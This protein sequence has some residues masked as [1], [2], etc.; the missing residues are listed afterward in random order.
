MR[1]R[2]GMLGFFK[3]IG[4][5]PRDVKLFLLYCLFANS[6]IA[7]FQ[8]IFNLYLVQL[9][10]REDYIGFFNGVQTVVM[11]VAGLTLGRVV[12]RFGIW[13][14]ITGGVGILF[15]V[16]FLLAFSEN[17][18]VIVLMA[19][20]FGY[21]LS[22]LFTMPMPFIIEFVPREER[23]HVAAVTVSLI[24]V[25]STIG[26]LL[27]GLL[28]RTLQ[29][30]FFDGGDVGL[31]A[32]RWTLVAGSSIAICGFFPLFAMRDVRHNTQ[33]QQLASQ[34]VEE[35]SA[36][37]RQTRGDMS[38]FVITAILMAL[39]V[40]MVIPFYNVFLTELGA[41][42]RQIGYIFALGSGIAAIVGLT[43]S[44]VSRRLGPLRG[45]A[46]IR[47]TTVAPSLLLVFSP[48]LGPAVLAQIVRQIGMNMTWPIDSTFLGEILPAR[49]RSTAFG[50]RSAAWNIGSAVAAVIGGWLI[51]TR[52]YQLTFIS[53]VVFS[54]LAPIVFVGYFWRHPRMKSG[55]V[56]SHL[57]EPGAAPAPAAPATP[58]S[59]TAD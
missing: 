42:A 20:F 5:F 48:A 24:A 30:Q 10:L 26:S 45:V 39:G 23:S 4:T 16:S 17:P 11:A 8:L 55:F 12:G 37:R 52:G 22:F 35:T 47:A 58:A 28:P 46:L 1:G 6:G 18:R 59:T 43:S 3:R 29:Q 31:L 13:R 53:Y 34:V 7:V 38:I 41:D 57:V 9:N 44:F 21:G 40:G 32:Y 50:L 54:A 19:A 33:A 14:A 56:V 2:I 49:L 25:S 27:G 36:E 51:V 15:V